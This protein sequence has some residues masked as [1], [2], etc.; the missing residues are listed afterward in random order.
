MPFPIWFANVAARIAI[1]V[2]PG[3]GSGH[4]ICGSPYSAARRSTS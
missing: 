4:T 1:K 3:Q 2:L